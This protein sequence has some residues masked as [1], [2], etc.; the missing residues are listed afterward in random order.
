MLRTWQII[1]FSG[2]A[3]MAAACASSTAPVGPSGYSVSMRRIV[4][5]ANTQNQGHPSFRLAPP[6]TKVPMSEATA[7][8]AVISK[9]NEGRGTR[10]LVAGLVTGPVTSGSPIYWAVFVDPPGRHIAPYA[11]PVR[12]P[13]IL[14]WIGAFVSVKTTQNPFCDFG[15]AANLPPLP[16]F[17]DPRSSHKPSGMGGPSR[18]AQQWTSAALRCAGTGSRQGQSIS[19]RTA[20]NAV[21]AVW[22]S[23]RLWAADTCIL[24]RALPAGTT[25]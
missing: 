6:G 5:D 17:A 20:A 11:E 14:N 25:G 9:C 24:I 4:A 7:A 21:A 16:V 8:R 10:V 13:Q 19:A 3:L 1:M 15:R 22:R 2:V 18:L 12:K 23:S